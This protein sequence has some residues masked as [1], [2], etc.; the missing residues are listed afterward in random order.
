MKRYRLSPSAR[1]DLK[2]IS[3]YLAVERQSPQGA[4]RLRGY[5]LDSFRLLAEQTLL[6]QAC[7]EYGANKRIWPV[8]K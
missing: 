8:A 7:P 4:E 6:G 2:Q 1:D 3:R 5:F